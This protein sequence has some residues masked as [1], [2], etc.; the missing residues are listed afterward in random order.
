MRI[1]LRSYHFSLSIFRNDLYNEIVKDNVDEDKTVPKGIAMT[2][3][4]GKSK[5]VL[6]KVLPWSELLQQPVMNHLNTSWNSEHTMYLVSKGR[7]FI[8]D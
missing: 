4:S 5:E 2:C 8:R 3:I 7:E 6:K 1:R